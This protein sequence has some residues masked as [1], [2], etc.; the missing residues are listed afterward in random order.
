MENI[1]MRN[2]IPSKLDQAPYGTQCRVPNSPRTG[3]ELYLQ[4]S[5]NSEEPNWE[6]MG[7]FPTIID[8]MDIKEI[9]S[10]R[11]NNH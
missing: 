10:K 4:V 2:G 3:F 8:P 11:L 6:L 7:Y 5:K 1:L 9:I